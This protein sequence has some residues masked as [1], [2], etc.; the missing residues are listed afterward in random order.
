MIGDDDSD[1]PIM[2]KVVETAKQAIKVITNAV[3][4]SAESNAPQPDE[5][6]E[7]VL[8]SPPMSGGA[9]LPEPVMPPFVVVSRRKSRAKK[10]GPRKKTMKR[11]AKK[12]TK[13]SKRALRKKGKR[14]VK[15]ST[16][17]AAKK[18]SKKTKKKTRKAPR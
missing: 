13:K 16:K 15:K 12:R 14:V 17:K 6:A 10:T 4:P 7:L 9:L 8:V 2:G 1:K 18:A 3:K 11:T 5:A